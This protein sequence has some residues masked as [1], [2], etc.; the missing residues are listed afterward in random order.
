MAGI[1][2]REEGAGEEE[3]RMGV[4]PWARGS[5]RVVIQRTDDDILRLTVGTFHGSVCHECSLRGA[6]CTCVNHISVSRPGGDPDCLWEG[7]QLP[8]EL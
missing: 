2:G 4:G 1:R 5:D 3:W 8:S 6:V 7:G